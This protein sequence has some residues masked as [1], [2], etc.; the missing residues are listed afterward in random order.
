MSVLAKSEKKTSELV[1]D[2]DG[3]P[4]GIKNQLR[5]LVNFGE[6]VRIRRGVYAL[7]EA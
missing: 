1:E 5:R 7:M 2:V 4:R 3:Y 6:I